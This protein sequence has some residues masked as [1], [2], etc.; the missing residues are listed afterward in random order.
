MSTK[1]TFGDDQSPGADTAWGWITAHAWPTWT[2]DI[3]T[4]KPGGT[5]TDTSPL[6]YD[7]LHDWTPEEPR[8]VPES[9]EFG[10]V[11]YRMA[12]H[13]PRV[14][15]GSCS[16]STVIVVGPR[17]KG[18]MKVLHIGSTTEWLM[19]CP[20]SPLLIARKATQTRSVLVCIDGSTHADAAVEVLCNMPWLPGVAVTVLAVVERDNAIRDHARAAADHLKAAGADVD[21]QIVIPDA[22]SVATNP[23]ITIYDFARGTQPDLIVLGTKGL[24]GLPRLRV[25]S[26]AS[27]IARHSDCSVLLV[28]D[29]GEDDGEN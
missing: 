27:A 22:L 16:D 15:L 19:Q 18:L 14:I 3:I 25:G 20:N 6:G 24:T 28:R 13:D 17:G 10:D 2:L 5:K 4:V 21:I 11:H 9:C 1:L 29:R 7:E 8:D 26:V 23:R 12:H